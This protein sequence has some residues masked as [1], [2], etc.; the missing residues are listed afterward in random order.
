MLLVFIYIK[1]SQQGFTLIY[2]Y[3]IIYDDNLHV[4]IEFIL[5]VE[6]LLYFG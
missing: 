2:I 3:S 4:I 5:S 1:G 6:Y